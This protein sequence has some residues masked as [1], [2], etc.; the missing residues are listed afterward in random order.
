M[1]KLV[2]VAGG[3]GFAGRHT[4]F[5]FKRAGFEV[6]AI[7]HGDFGPG[8]CHQYGIDHWVSADITLD[9]LSAIKLVPS[10]IVN[11]SGSGSVGLSFKDPLADFNKTVNSTISLLEFIRQKAPLAKFIQLSSPAVCGDHED[12]LIKVTDPLNPIS[13]YGFHKKAAEDACLFYHRMG[14][15]DIAIIRFFSL[16]GPG[17]KKQLFWDAH[18][19]IKLNPPVLEFFGTGE[20]TRDWLYIDDAVDLILKVARFKSPMVQIFNGASGQKRTIRETMGC[21]LDAA[22][23]RADLK[24]NGEARPGDPR[25]YWADISGSLELGWSP[26]TTLKQGIQRY[27][28]WASGIKTEN[29]A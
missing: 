18:G 19:K 10:V 4:A 25:F 23:S 14:G 13:P 6:A 11:C 22:G 28:S 26:S 20:E 3:F 8:Q 2:L 29:S 16:Y 5:A 7:G 21:F 24:F 1:K 15:L 9:N 12:A 17:L 27:I